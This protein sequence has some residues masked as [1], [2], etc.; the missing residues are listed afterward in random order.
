MPPNRTKINEIWSI[1]PVAT[2]FYEIE[3]WARNMS[4]EGGKVEGVMG[5]GGWTDRTLVNPMIAG[6]TS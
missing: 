6:R 4:F 3:N 2:A 5:A 1:C